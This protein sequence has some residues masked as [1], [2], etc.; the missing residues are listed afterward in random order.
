LFSSDI[1]Q[2]KSITKTIRKHLFIVLKSGQFQSY[3]FIY[4][5]R[6]VSFLYP[7][8]VSVNIVNYYIIDSQRIPGRICWTSVVWV[9]VS[10]VELSSP[11][12]PMTD[13]RTTIGI[14]FYEGRAHVS[15][16]ACIYIVRVPAAVS[17]A[18]ISQYGS[19]D[20]TEVV[21]RGRSYKAPIH[22][23]LVTLH[24]LW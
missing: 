5:S 6:S 3:T 4:F 19:T 8:F 22:E 1:N 9:L 24:C 7:Q 12:C 23:A 16:S 21:S 2:I 15:V 11:V 17:C 18:S 14:N 20:Y 10:S 13:R